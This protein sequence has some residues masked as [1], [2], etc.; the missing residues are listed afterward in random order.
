MQERAIPGPAS[1]HL[2]E[3]LVFATSPFS[4]PTLSPRARVSVPSS[5]SRR[6]VSRPQGSCL[7]EL[8]FHAAPN[9]QQR[10]LAADQSGSLCLTLTPTVWGGWGTGEGPPQGVWGILGPGGQAPGGPRKLLSACRDIGGQEGKGS[11]ASPGSAPGG[12]VSQ[13]P[14]STLGDTDTKSLRTS[15][16]VAAAYLA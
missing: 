4:S 13:G 15:T 14:P 16:E 10:A 11:A 12:Q 1:S 8:N 3:A 9:A 5:E 2:W 7:P 6:P